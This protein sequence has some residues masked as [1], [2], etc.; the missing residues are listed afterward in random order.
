MNWKAPGHDKIPNFWL[1]SMP[2]IHTYLAQC[3][4]Q[5]VEQTEEMPEWIVRGKTTLL[6][7]SE[8]TTDASQYRPITCLT[9]M[10][11]CL[12]GMIGEKIATFMNEN[13]M[14][15]VEQQGGIKKSYG[16]KTQLLINRNILS[17]AARNKKNL[18]MLYVDY[19]KSIRFCAARLDKR[20]INCLQDL[21]HHHQ[22]YMYINADV[23]G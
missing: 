9:T 19:K 17:D 4:N 23:E 3:F 6:P 2:T 13:S 15:A 21:S 18:H 20:V 5:C 10:W 12:T 16:T 14:L 8:K 7:K 11:K 22:L 1:K